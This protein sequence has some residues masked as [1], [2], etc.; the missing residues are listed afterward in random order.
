MSAISRREFAVL[1]SSI[2]AT[3]AWGHARPAASRTNWRE[4]R[5]HFPE[6]VASGD[7]R[8]DQHRPLSD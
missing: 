1:A 7:P 2:G 4:Q 8:H 5:D 3:I 6:G